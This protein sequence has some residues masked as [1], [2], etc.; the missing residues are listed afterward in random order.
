MFCSLRA[1]RSRVLKLLI[2]L[3]CAHCILFMATYTCV[4]YIYIL[5]IYIL[6]K[7]ILKS[8]HQ[9]VKSKS[10]SLAYIYIK[11]HLLKHL[12]ET[13]RHLTYRLL[14]TGYYF[15]N[16]GHMLLIFNIYIIKTHTFNIY[17]YI[18]I[19]IYILKVYIYIYKYIYYINI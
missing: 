12:Y 3:T 19:Y 16:S 11:Q 10:K 17:I 6:Y 7:L 15:Q 4:Y 1:R 5:Y 14:F 2:D 8:F 9:N 13:L 18:Y